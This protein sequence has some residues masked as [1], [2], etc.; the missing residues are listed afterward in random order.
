MRIVLKDANTN[1]SYLVKLIPR[2]VKLAKKLLN[3]FLDSVAKHSEKQKVPT[4]LFTVLI[5]MH[6]MSQDRLK[7]ITP[8]TNQI[9]LN[10]AYKGYENESKKNDET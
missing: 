4:L 8:E 2:D 10:S 5:M 7:A 3:G 1:R 6:V 9:I